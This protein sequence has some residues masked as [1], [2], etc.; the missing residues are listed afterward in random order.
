MALEVSQVTFDSSKEVGSGSFG[1]VYQGKYKEKKCAVKVFNIGTVRHLKDLQGESKLASIM[2]HHPNV[3]LIHG[4][5]Y[6]SAASF[7]NQPALVM[8]FCDTN[9]Q[10]YLQEKFHRGDDE[11]FS[12]ATKL[13]LLWDI[14]AG[15]AYLHSEQIVHG[16]LSANNVLLDYNGSKLVAKVGGF[17]QSRLLNL[18]AVNP[19]KRCDIMPPEVKDFQGPVK[20]TKAVDV[21]SFGCLIP[22]V[23]SCVY[24]EP[25]SDP[26]SK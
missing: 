3:V 5:W 11:S 17:D 23:A 16:S 15:M 21:F 4:L 13:E 12:T 25:K 6:S 7:N 2:Q 14:A 18:E 9:L 10:V 20:L 22:H 8:E 24:P 19:G 26:L 1:T